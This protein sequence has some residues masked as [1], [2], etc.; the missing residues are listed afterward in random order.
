MGCSSSV[1]VVGLVVTLGW[2]KDPTEGVVGMEMC[3]EPAQV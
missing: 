1:M 3:G 2:Q